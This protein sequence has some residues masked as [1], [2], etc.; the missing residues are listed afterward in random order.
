MKKPVRRIALTL[1]EESF[2]A[3]RE[4][5]GDLLRRGERPSISAAVRELARAEF[6]RRQQKAKGTVAVA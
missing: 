3:L 6:K 2:Q 1:T 5:Q 4:V